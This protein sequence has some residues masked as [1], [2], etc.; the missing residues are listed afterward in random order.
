VAGQ[1]EA[2]GA[3]VGVA[4]ERRAL[5]VCVGRTGEDRADHRSRQ[6]VGQGDAVSMSMR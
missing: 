6:L 5:D 2:I 1:L 4:V 3:G